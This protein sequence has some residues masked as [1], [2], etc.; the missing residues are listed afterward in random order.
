MSDMRDDLDEL[1]RRL[2][3]TTDALR[4]AGAAARARGSRVRRF[5]PLIT[6]AAAV[7]LVGVIGGAVLLGRS[8]SSKAPIPAAPTSS[9]S[10]PVI[11]ATPSSTPSSSPSPTPAPVPHVIVW[12]AVG[13]SSTAIRVGDASGGFHTVATIAASTQPT[14]LGAGGHR[15]LFSRQSNGHLYDLDINTGTVTDH[16]GSGGV[17]FFG[18]AFSPDGT[19]VEYLRLTPQGTGQILRLDFGNG[20]ITS[21]R[22]FGQQPMDVPRVWT[23]HGV[24]AS[25]QYLPVSDSPDAGFAILDPSTGAVIA[26]TDAQMRP[27]AWAVA[28][29][30]VHAAHAVGA[31]P[32]STPQAV[33][34]TEVIGSAP[35]V[36]VH[37]NANHI[38]TVLAASPD[39]STVLY[40]DDPSMGGYAGISL[41]SDY[42]LFTIAAGHSSQVAHYGSPAGG[43]SAG[44]FL[45]GIDYVLV[46]TGG[47]EATLLHSAGGGSP[48]ALDR[49]AGTSGLVWVVTGQ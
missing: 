13:S 30:G 17:R 40:R 15:V 43:S 48:A 46:S 37:E 35:R 10:A 29:D 18:A 27:Q 32:G 34:D 19:E 39:G 41:S 21:L 36:A 26:T 14:I 6:L 23:A 44:A 33:L 16:G 45:S 1:G 47:S 28:A 9:P 12:A 49:A 4:P 38:I 20:A 25:R 11:S 24:A 5:E 31:P 2:W 22:S 7:L 42:G 8:L 3:P